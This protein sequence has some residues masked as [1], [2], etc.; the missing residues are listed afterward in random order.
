[1]GKFWIWRINM[2]NTPDKNLYKPTVGSTGWGES[3]NGNFDILDSVMGMEKC[4]KFGESGVKSYP[5]TD[6]GLTTLLSE[7]VSGD[8][9]YLY[10]RKYETAYTIPGGVSIFGLVKSKTILSKPVIIGDLTNYTSLISNLCIS[11]RDDPA[12]PTFAVKTG[13]SPDPYHIYKFQNVDIELISRDQTENLYGIEITGTGNIYVDSCL[14]VSSGDGYAYAVG[15]T[16]GLGPGWSG[17]AHFINFRFGRIDDLAYATAETGM[18]LSIDETRITP[19]YSGGGV[20]TYF[21]PIKVNGLSVFPAIQVSNWAGTGRGFY[22]KNDNIDI[23]YTD[24]ETNR[25]YAEVGYDTGYPILTG[26]TSTITVVTALQ[27]SSGTLQQKTRALEFNGGI[28]TAVGAESAW[29]NV[30]SV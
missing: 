13:D 9:V 15:N 2:A 1:M 20:D 18:E 10:P 26:Q 19:E 27:N 25:V 21:G 23:F 22:H 5:A 3:V 30:P 6:E 16:T 4:I 8:T 29:T 12:Q 7:A 24:A 17:G 28:I 14:I 11:I